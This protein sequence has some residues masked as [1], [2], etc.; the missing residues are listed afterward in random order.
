MLF[1]PQGAHLLSGTDL[2][3][4]C[5]PPGETRAGCEAVGSNWDRDSHWQAA[6]TVESNGRKKKTTSPCAHSISSIQKD[7]W[8]WGHINLICY[9]NSHSQKQ[10]LIAKWISTGSFRA[11][12]L[13]TKHLMHSWRG[14][15]SM[16]RLWAVC[17]VGCVFIP[18]RLPS[19]ASQP[20]P[21]MHSNVKVVL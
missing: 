11:D 3:R 13:Q 1:R 19:P 20:T 8:S 7:G 17:A 6:G 5:H 2:P 4:K 15:L 10:A 9:S 14:A 12:S 21:I 18:K 16:E